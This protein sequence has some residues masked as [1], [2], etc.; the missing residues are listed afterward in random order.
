MQRYCLDSCFWAEYF[1]GTELGSNARRV[2]ETEEILFT[3]AVALTEIEAAAIKHGKDASE[4]YQI[5]KSHSAIVPIT[6]RIARNAAEVK[7]RHGVY[8]VDALVYAC[9]RDTGAVLLTED[10]KLLKLKGVKSLKHL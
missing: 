10:E 9:A 3:P 8:T 2:L 1:Q 4:Q 6:A 7:A 5:I